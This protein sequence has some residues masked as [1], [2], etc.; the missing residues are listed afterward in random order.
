MLEQLAQN[1]SSQPVHLVYGVTH[2]HDLV[3][4]DQLEQYR[5]RLPNFS[6]LTCAAHRRWWKRY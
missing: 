4:L 5:A 3:K 6:Y 2:E 1:G